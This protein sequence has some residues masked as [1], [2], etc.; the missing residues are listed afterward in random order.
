[1]LSVHF[2][3]PPKS[4][5]LGL[6]AIS[7]R[8]ILM[9]ISVH[10]D[11]FFIN[12]FPNLLYSDGVLEIFSFIN[13]NFQHTRLSYYTPLTYYTFILFQYPYHLISNSFSIWMTDLYK[14][15]ISRTQV[16]YTK[17]YL[18]Q[19]TNAF[20]F[21]DLF[22]AKIPYLI[23]EAGSLVILFKF[24]KLKYLKPTSIFAWLF[25]PIIIYSA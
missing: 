6:L 4:I 14:F 13:N 12:M 20:L 5:I 7:I 9:P 18:E 8:L 1:M 16:A 25:A 2:K 17:D 3:V 23:F 19:I 22:L 15:Y 21:R 11:L 10:P 24:V